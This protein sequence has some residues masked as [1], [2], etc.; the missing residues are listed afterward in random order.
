MVII[1]EGY[2]TV[3][4]T[5]AFPSNPDNVGAGISMLDLMT[6]ERLW[7]AGRADADLELPTLTR[8][9]P[10]QVRAIDFSGDG[11]IDRMYAVDVGASCSDS[12]FMPGRT[13]RRW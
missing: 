3:H 6:G 11:F 12:T 1:G 4:D 13:H 8:A 9:I 5:A 2:D 10:S 7:R